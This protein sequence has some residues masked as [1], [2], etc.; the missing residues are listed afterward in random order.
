MNTLQR[1]AASVSLAGAALLGSVSTAYAGPFIIA[2]TD[3]DDHGSFSAGA[4][5]DGWFFMQR[6][7]ESLAPAVTNGNKQVV[8]LGS[9]Q[10][11]QAGNAAASAFNNSSLVAAGWTSVFINDA[12]IGTF[13]SGGAA[14]AGIIMMDSGGNVTGGATT[15][16]RGLFTTNAAAINTFVGNGGGLFSQANGY[17][18]I[19]ALLPTLGDVDIQNQ[20]LALTAAGSAAFPGLNNGDLSA[21]PWHNYFTNVGA[22][23]VFATST[24]SATLGQAVI[25]GAVSGSITNP[26]PVGVPDAGSFAFVY[27]AL[28]GLLVA[29][30]RSVRRSAA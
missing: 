27:I 6:A 10:N 22:L 29:F 23:T 17:G 9:D 18:W 19:S 20:G 13:L 25:I 11:T 14:G 26:D 12:A 5:Q 15:T 3:A 30:R 21:G 1:L 4:N 16:E 2:G 24:Q 7:L 28:G 8:F